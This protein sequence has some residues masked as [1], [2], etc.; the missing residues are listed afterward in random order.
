MS[1]DG[2]LVPDIDSSMTLCPDFVVCRQHHLDTVQ[3]LQACDGCQAADLAEQL[4]EM[5]ASREQ[6]GG[7]EGENVA[8]EECSCLGDDDDDDD[9]DD[10]DCYVSD[11]GIS[12]CRPS[13]VREQPPMPNGWECDD[14]DD[15]ESDANSDGYS[16]DLDFDG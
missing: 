11:E 9:D 5:S 3:L 4:D 2:F 6:E 16:D 8:E 12:L 13:Y 14:G 15:A 10:G 7:I 1:P